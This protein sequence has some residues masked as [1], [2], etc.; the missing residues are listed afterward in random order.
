MFSP[1]YQFSH[2]F[3]PSLPVLS[4]FYFLLVL[5]RNAARSVSTRNSNAR[6]PRVIPV[7]GA[8]RASWLKFCLQECRRHSLPPF[9]CRCL[10]RFAAC[11][12]GHRRFRV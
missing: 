4:P 9:I 1:F 11:G 2:F 8:R 7:H 6:R 5:L 12:L 10:C 3:L